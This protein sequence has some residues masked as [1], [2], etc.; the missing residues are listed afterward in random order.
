MTAGVRSIAVLLVLLAATANARAADEDPPIRN[1]EARARLVEGLR[2]FADKQY[3]EAA[4]ELLKGLAIEPHPDLAYALG[5][6]ER[7]LGQCAKAIEHYNV[8]LRTS[9]SKVKSA[10]AEY[11]LVR[12]RATLDAERLEKPVV[13][14]APD[15]AKPLDAPEAPPAARVSLAAPSPW[16]RDTAGMTLTVAGGVTLVSG[17]GLFADAEHTIVGGQSQ[18]NTWNASADAVPRQIAGI[19]ILS[20]GGAVLVGGAVRLALVSR[21][22]HGV[23]RAPDPR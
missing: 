5:Q 6:A 21:R 1:A 8:V 3:A 23:A 20:V 19:V 2:R 12:C 7:H 16:Y 10:H 22:A 9:A 17:L 15:S 13:P 18:W 14:P 11:Q 4:E